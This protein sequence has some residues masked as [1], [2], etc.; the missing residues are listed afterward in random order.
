MKQH[1]QRSVILFKT[2]KRY[3]RFYATNSGTV[4]LNQKFYL[5]LFSS[6]PPFPLAMLTDRF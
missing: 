6:R 1:A 4:R 2:M 3:L 5:P